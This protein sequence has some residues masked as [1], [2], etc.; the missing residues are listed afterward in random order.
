[1]IS[2][3]HKRATPP[4]PD[5]LGRLSATGGRRGRI[6]LNRVT[7]R[8]CSEVGHEVLLMEMGKAVWNR[9]VNRIQLLVLCVSTTE[10]RGTL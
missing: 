4:A 9:K 5:T 6:P 2:T 10:D 7:G 3:E 1:M 8:W